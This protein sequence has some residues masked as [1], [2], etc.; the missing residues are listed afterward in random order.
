LAPLTAAVAWTALLVQL[1]LS[2]RGGVARGET[3]ARAVADYL[4]F[5]TILTN[6]LVALVLT[7]PPVAPRSAA[8]RGL[9]HPMARW[10][11]A[12]AILVVGIAYHLLLS[13]LYNPT[14]VEALTDLGFHYLVPAL[15]ALT[16][17]CT[18]PLPERT[19]LW[20]TLGVLS[21]YPVAY[22]VYLLGRGA[23]VGS[24][25]Y[26][27]VDAGALG[28]S[29]AFRNAMGL[30]AVHLLLAWALRAA[31]VRVQHRLAPVAVIPAA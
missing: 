10:T 15:Y 31:A 2:I 8:G 23:V 11:A 3:V 25:P 17:L 22:F 4:S 13:A 14:G 21:A 26:F 19:P 29:G 18:L 1:P 30:L 5:Y 6:L 24:Y 28:V 20:P 7:V 16:W 27:F 9:G 12:A